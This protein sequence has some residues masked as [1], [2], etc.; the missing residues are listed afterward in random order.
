MGEEMRSKGSLISTSVILLLVLA[1]QAPAAGPANQKAMVIVVEN[2]EA[3]TYS[4]KPSDFFNAMQEILGMSLGEL[5]IPLPDIL[6]KAVKNISGVRGDLVDTIRKG[7]RGM[8]SQLATPAEVIGS[9]TPR[10]CFTD[11]MQVLSQ[12][13][14]TGPQPGNVF[15]D[16]YGEPATANCLRD[17]AA[18][19][20]EK[21]VVLTDQQATFAN[22]KQN[23][24]GLN[25]AGYR[26]DIL[27][28]VHGC[29]DSSVLNNG[30]CTKNKLLF[31]KPLRGS[32]DSYEITP[33]IL[34]GLNG[35]Q[36]MNLNAVYM[37]SCWGSRFNKSWMKLG[38]KAVNGSQEL[39]YYVIASPLLF[40]HYW[41]KE[42]LPLHEAATKAYGRERRFFSGQNLEIAFRWRDPITGK[43][44][45]IDKISI[46]ITWR[47][48]M[49]KQLSKYHGEDKKRPINHEASSQRVPAGANG[50]TL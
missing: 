7:Y 22:F 5:D 14:A 21:V 47:K 15:L 32:D 46:G 39:N 27:L 11:M 41:T 3:Q 29:G 13:F 33:A 37:T 26:I 42:R 9:A 25:K 44:H 18:P 34:E 24:E 38:A 2:N 40:L 48:L 31:A 6:D 43:K 50:V 30:P 36:P 17:M 19:Y 8:M 23:V 4:G 20:Y 1:A 12:S 28:D 49:N 45:T 10:N 16:R 35:G